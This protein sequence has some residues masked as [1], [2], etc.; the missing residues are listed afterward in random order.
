LGLFSQ[1]MQTMWKNGIGEVDYF[2][3]FSF[4]DLAWCSQCLKIK[5]NVILAR[6]ATVLSFK[7]I[8]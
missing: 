2:T 8:C 3:F 7:V 5:Y 6:V 1:I 4:L